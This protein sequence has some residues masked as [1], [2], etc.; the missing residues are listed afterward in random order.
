MHALLAPVLAQLVTLALGDR[1]EAHYVADRTSRYF[2]A[3]N[4]MVPGA[5]LSLDWKRATVG[6]GYLPTLTFVPLIHT[7]RE[8]YLYHRGLVT[9]QYRFRH[10]TIGISQLA[11]FGERN[12]QLEA[13]APQ[14]APVAV[15]GTQGNQ[16]GQQPPRNPPAGATTGS[17]TT[18]TNQPTQPTQPTQPNRPVRSDEAVPFGEL[19]TA[20]FVDQVVS[21][22]V[23]FR[24][25]G[26]YSVSG[27]TSHD[28]Q[29]LY[30][31]ARGPDGAASVRYVVDTR[32]SFA[33]TLT[34]QL[35][36]SEVGT[37]SFVANATED[38][39]H[40]FTRRTTGTLGVGVSF[41]RSEP[42]CNLVLVSIYPTGR[43]G[44]SHTDRLARGTLTFSLTLSSSPVLDLTTGAVD[45]RVAGAL[46]TSWGRDRFT[47][48]ASVSTTLSLDRGSLQ[49]FNS[50]YSQFSIRYDV[51]AG[52]A[53]D[54]GARAVWQTYGGDTSITPSIVLFVGLN[55]GLVKPLNPRRGQ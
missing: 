35:L 13:L 36:F 50:V 8:V 52:F 51:G 17:G 43:A 7:P 41:T 48:S 16:T 1:I 42:V 15:Q 14:Q 33:T 4:T 6:V 49:A 18:G 21:K 9:G 23:S 5:A 27:G 26:G 24:L 53:T 30:P 29:H 37:D 11:G 34:G 31:L 20:A 22:A 28:A 39:T 46:T 54:A 2:E 40:L 19:R 32:N 25:Q 38:Y 45:P 12:F 47:S 44:L 3:M 10:T 55:W